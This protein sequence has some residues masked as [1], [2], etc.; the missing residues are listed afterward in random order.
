VRF[1]RPVQLTR[2]TIEIIAMISRGDR[3]EYQGQLYQLP[4]PDSRGRAIRPAAPPVPVPIYVAAI[5]PA[6]LRLCGELAD[7]WLGNAF[8]PE[9]AAVFL[10]ELRAGAAE[11]GAPWATWTCRC[12]WRSNS[13]TT[14]TRP[15]PG[16]PRATR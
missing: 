2:E 4:L 9:T 14:S 6:N 5:G 12:R 7:G 1:R 16:T 15:K 11:A 8:I 10:D 13:P 3:L